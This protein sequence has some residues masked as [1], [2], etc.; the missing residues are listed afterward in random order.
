MNEQNAV[1]HQVCE[2]AESAPAEQ[3]ARR[4][5]VAADIDRLGE[6]VE[7]GDTDHGACTESQDQVQLVA[8]PEREQS[9]RE[10]AH[11][12]GDGDGCE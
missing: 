10:G 1:Q 3:R 11:E 12:G 4:L 8:Q 2:K 6:Q 9:S 5:G 7:E